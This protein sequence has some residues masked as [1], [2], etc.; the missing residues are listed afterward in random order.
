MAIEVLSDAEVKI[1]SV[2]LSEYTREVSVNYK[3]RIEDATGMNAT[4]ATT[5]LQSLYDWSVDI[6]FNQDFAASKVNA[7]LMALDAAGGQTIEVM[8]NLTDGVSATN[9]RWTGT[10]ILETYPIIGGSVG[11]THTTAVTIQGSGA[12]TGATS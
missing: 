4:G 11:D 7:T 8:A 10:G 6:T 12:L 2:D 9:P 5:K 1:N 3:R